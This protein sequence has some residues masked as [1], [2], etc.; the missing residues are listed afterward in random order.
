LCETRPLFTQKAVKVK[1]LIVLVFA[2]GLLSC[3][4]TS[5]EASPGQA[6]SGTY[7]AKTYDSFGQVMNYPLNAQTM[8]IQIT[9]VSKDSARV[10]VNSTTNGYYSPG[11]AA[12]YPKVMVTETI[13]ANCQY[14]KT[15]KIS[16]APPVDPGTLENSIWFDPQY[17]AYYTYIPPG[18]TKGAVQTVLVKSN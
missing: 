9:A 10:E 1:L 14:C 16:F 7:E 5:V 4:K 11:D 12:V 13:C 3:K 6:I 2:F 18:Y 8:S 15:Y 17:N